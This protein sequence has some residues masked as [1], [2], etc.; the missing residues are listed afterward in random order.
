MNTPVPDPDTA[1]RTHPVAAALTAAGLTAQV[2]VTRGVARA[3]PRPAARAGRGPVGRADLEWRHHHHRGPVT[4]GEA[5]P[6]DQLAKEILGRIAAGGSVHPVPDWLVFFGR[7]SAGEV[8]ARLAAWRARRARA[9]P[10]ARSLPV[11]LQKAGRRCPHPD[12]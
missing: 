1:L 10:T 3:S 11:P 7:T 9:S 12:R 8:A 6:G 5:Q 4:A 2:H